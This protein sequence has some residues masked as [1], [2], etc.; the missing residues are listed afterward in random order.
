MALSSRLPARLHR[1]RLVPF[2]AVL[3]LALLGLLYASLD[4]PAP[5]SAPSFAGQ[6]WVDPKLFDTAEELA[7][8]RGC[9]V[10]Q[11][12]LDHLPFY[13][14]LMA[15]APLA[16]TPDGIVRFSPPTEPR[17]ASDRPD[18]ADW[19]PVLRLMAQAERSFRAFVEGQSRTLAEAELA[20]RRRWKRPPPPGFEHWSV[21][22]LPRP[23]SR[24]LR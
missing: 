22:P 14:E 20:Y 1:A 8:A 3:A 19:H 12:V 17:N 10:G 15:S 11:S 18:D 16:P 2:S 24:R 5:P 21:A 6:T 9:D 23:G 13:A 4:L 7:F